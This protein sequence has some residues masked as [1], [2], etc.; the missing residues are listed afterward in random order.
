MPPAPSCSR[1]LLQRA[2]PTRCAH[3]PPDRVCAWACIQ[4]A[5][6]QDILIG[7]VLERSRSWALERAEPGQDAVQQ[8]LWEMYNG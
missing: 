4:G 3:C 7:A 5:G 6:Y 1:R 2:S 8:A